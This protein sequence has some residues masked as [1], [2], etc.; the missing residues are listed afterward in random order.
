[1]Q[2]RTLKGALALAALGLAGCGGSSSSSSSTAGSGAAPLASSPTAAAAASTG[3][4]ASDAKDCAVPYGDTPAALSTITSGD[5]S[6]AV[7]DVLALLDQCATLGG[8]TL[9]WTDRQSEVRQACLFV[10]AN[11]SSAAP[12]PLLVFL[13]GSL[14]P[15]PPQL[16]INDWISLMNTADLNGDPQNPGF[17]LLLPIGR[18]TH[19]F[20]PFPD[21]YALGFDNW[22]RNLDRSSPD[23][24]LDVAAVDQFITQVEALDIVDSNRVYTTGWSNGAALA[25]LYALNTPS[26]AA[27]AVYSAPAPYSDVQDPC[28][29]SPF[30]TTMTPI[31]DIHNSCDIIGTCQTS[32][33]FHQNLAQLYPN[34]PQNVVLIDGAS[35]VQSCDASC[36]SQSIAGDPVGNV[37]HVIWPQNQNDALFTWLRQ[38]PLSSKQ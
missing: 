26:I 16:I 34:L 31:M 22:Y 11:A 27:A 38:H 5:G 24:N 6:S 4:G 12:L 18:D 36:A 14:V 35:V 37:N 21:E 25:E 13:Q 30:I 28:Y 1:M 10:P 20:Y 19:H 2:L 8:Q 23:L 17:V 33:A 32:S 15:A 7:E 29:Q 9:S 3:P